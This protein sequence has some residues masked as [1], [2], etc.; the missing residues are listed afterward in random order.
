MGQQ[1]QPYSVVLTGET[2]YH[3]RKERSYRG[4]HP[5]WLYKQRQSQAKCLLPGRQLEWG[6]PTNGKIWQSA[7]LGGSWE[8]SNLCL[9]A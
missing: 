5:C 8:E 6:F 9:L 2:L 7:G 3:S 1:E 4:R